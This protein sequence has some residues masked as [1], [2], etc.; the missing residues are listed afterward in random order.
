MR[1]HVKGRIFGREKNTREALVR[2]LAVSLIDKEKITTTEAKAKEIRPFVEKLVT[3]GK[4]GTLGA[5][6]ILVSRLNDK[7]MV[8]KLV[9]NISPR[10]K[11]RAGGYL[12]IMKLGRRLKDGSPMCVIEFV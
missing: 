2:S 10:Y 9:E 12:R 8:K 1:H 11:E 4:S 5:I 6:R 7:E 3:R